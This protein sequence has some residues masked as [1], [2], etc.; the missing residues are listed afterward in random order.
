MAKHDVRLQVPEGI[1][2]GNR[3]FEFKVEQDSTHLGWLKVSR[4]A[5]V[6]QPAR[7]R[8]GF[9]MSWSRFDQLMREQGLEGRF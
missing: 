5:V 1:P 7:K 6:W 8:T 9:R 2:V 4:G 3:D